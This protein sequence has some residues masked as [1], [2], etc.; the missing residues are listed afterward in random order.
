MF[1]SVP[2]KSFLENPKLR[3]LWHATFPKIQGANLISSLYFL[4]VAKMIFIYC[5][6]SYHRT[7]FHIHTTKV[8]FIKSWVQ[9]IIKWI[10]FL[11]ANGLALTSLPY[12]LVVAKI[13][14]F[15]CGG[16]DK[17]KVKVWTLILLFSVLS[18]WFSSIGLCYRTRFHNCAT[19]VIF[20]KHHFQ[21]RRAF[22]L[23]WPHMMISC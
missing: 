14:F 9:K 5:S 4:V 21:K 3:K 2:P 11:K 7:H 19:K 12:F 20:K 18:K 15:K 10:F 13:F 22:W 6:G 17:K 8:I 23:I 1:I 16:F